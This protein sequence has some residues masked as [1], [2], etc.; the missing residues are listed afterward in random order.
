MTHFISP[1]K[2]SS[3]TIGKTKYTL[4]T[5]TDQLGAMG[6]YLSEEETG[7]AQTDPIFLSEQQ[8]K[9]FKMLLSNKP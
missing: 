8:A 9:A 3:L 5:C 6:H 1:T 7:K 2:T 4:D